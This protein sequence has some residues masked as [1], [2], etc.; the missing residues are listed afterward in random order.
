MSDLRRQSDFTVHD[1]R[2]VL[3]VIKAKEYECSGDSGNVK[4]QDNVRTQNDHV[5]EQFSQWAWVTDSF[6]ASPVASS[7]TP[8]V[9]TAAVALPP[10]MPA[11][12]LMALVLTVP[13]VWQ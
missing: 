5:E 8:P 7:E 6:L 10:E 11:F 2:V 12:F 4:I 13:L 3:K 9:S 1:D